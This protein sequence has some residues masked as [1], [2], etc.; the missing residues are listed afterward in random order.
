MSQSGIEP[1]PPRWEVSTLAKSYLNCVIIVIQNFFW[2]Y[3]PPTWLSLVH[4]VTWTY[5]NAHAAL[6]CRLNSTCKSFNPEYWHQALARPHILCQAKQI[7]NHVRVTTMERLDHP[8][9]K[10]PRMT[11]LRPGI[12]TRPPRWEEGTL[13]KSYSNSVLAIGNIYIWACDSIIH[14]WML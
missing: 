4:V 9:V 12:T 2:T 5:M 7:T 11:W 6:G 14:K 3:E 8:K 1:M 13:A 10:V